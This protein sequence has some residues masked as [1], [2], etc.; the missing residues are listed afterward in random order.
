VRSDLVQTLARVEEANQKV[1]QVERDL[2]AAR[3]E[4]RDALR[5]AHAAGASYTQLGAVIGKGR[6]RAR[7]IATG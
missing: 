5:A 4:L 7:R 1:E 2:D 3:S 6:E